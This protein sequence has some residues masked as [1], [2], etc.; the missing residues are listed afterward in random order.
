MS[1]FI[2]IKHNIAGIK[3]V[4]LVIAKDKSPPFMK[5]INIENNGPK[6][7]SVV[8]IKLP[9]VSPTLGLINIS[10]IKEKA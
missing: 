8:I 1:S 5:P 6:K 4:I 7:K 9:F 3:G 2:K 10:I